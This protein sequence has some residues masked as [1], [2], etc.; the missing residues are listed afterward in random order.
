V[1]AEY[2]RVNPFAYRNLLPTQNY[3]QY[4]VT[5]GDWVGNNFDREIY[6]VKYTPIPKLKT[7]LRYQKIRKGGPGT[8]AQ[9]YLDKKQPEFLFDLQ[10]KTTDIFV[11]ATYELINN[12]Y[13]TGSYQYLNQKLVN[14]IKATNTS[15]QLGMTFGLK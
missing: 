11:K 13:V 10:K 6:F 8:I 1:G 9:Q 14:G 5:L 3:T 2:T 7:Y 4:D 15:I 12:F